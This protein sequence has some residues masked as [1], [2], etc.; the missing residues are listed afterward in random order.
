[1]VRRKN[2]GVD[3]QL[4]YRKRLELALIVSL[5]MHLTL[6][7]IFPKME[8]APAPVETKDVEIE[9]EDIPVTEHPS[10]PAPPAR[11]S[12]PIPTESE[13]V[14]EN[15]TIQSTE[16]DFDLTELPPAPPPKDEKSIEDEY[17]FIP[18]DEPPVPIGGLDAIRANLRYPQIAR[19]AGIEAKVVVGVL[20][21]EQGTPL[22]A[23]ILKSSGIHLGFEEAAI[24]A[25]MA[26]RWKPAMQRDHPVKVW[27]SVPIRF[28]LQDLKNVTS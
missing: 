7:Q 1:M 14:P 11:P 25:V 4:K 23:D 27:V 2:P 5:V 18:Y 12:V 9:V 6:F 3:L 21:D 17:V 15:I 19:Q 10:M 22:K 24:D 28:K 16:L 20:I 26:V 13:S 8:I